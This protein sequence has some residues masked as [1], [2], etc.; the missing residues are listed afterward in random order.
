MSFVSGCAR[1]VQDENGDLN[2]ADPS[3]FFKTNRVDL[4][5]KPPLHCLFHVPLTGL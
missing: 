1:L 2:L 3:L 4:K 5:G